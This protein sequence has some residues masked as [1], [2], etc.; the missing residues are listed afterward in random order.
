MTIDNVQRMT[1]EWQITQLLN[2]WVFTRDTMNV[3]E[4]LETWTP[5]GSMHVGFFSG[6]CRDFMKLVTQKQANSRHFLGTPVIK[7]N[8]DRAQAD[9]YALLMARVEE[10]PGPLDLL[11]HVRYHDMLLKVDGQWKLH[12]RYAVFEKDRVDFV[13]PPGWKG[14][15]YR[16][17]NHVA[18]RHYKPQARHLTFVWNKVMKT[19][20]PPGHPIV[21]QSLE[22]AAVRF[23]QN[24]W[25]SGEH[26][27]EVSQSSV[28]DALNNYRAFKE[29]GESSRTG[30]QVA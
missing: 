11:A 26:G 27:E 17:L 2:R 18:L 15:I 7:L 9:T 5:E 25:L 23:E 20:S 3:R 12:K 22:A 8:G 24:G 29:R 14:M 21:D 4:H 28:V 30:M 1:D 16:V 10:R 13:A 6:N 19:G